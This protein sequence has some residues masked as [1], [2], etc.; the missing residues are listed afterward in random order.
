MRFLD[1]ILAMPIQAMTLP[2]FK[3]AAAIRS[4]F[5]IAYWDAAI[6][7]AARALGCEAVYSE[8]LS[9]RQDYG[10]IRVLDPFESQ[11]TG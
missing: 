3:E 6:L 11:A 1:P 4:R 9:S 8:D 10:G 2:V 7:A 5:G